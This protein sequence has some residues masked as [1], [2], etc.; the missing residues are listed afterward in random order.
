[1]SKHTHEE[2]P[3]ISQRVGSATAAGKD[4]S[5]QPFSQ[6]AA[7]RQNNEATTLRWLLWSTRLIVVIGWG[8]LVIEAMGRVLTGSV[9]VFDDNRL[10]I[11]AAI[12]L[13]STISAVLMLGSNNSNTC[14]MRADS[15]SGHRGGQRP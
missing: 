6:S 9:F 1:V 3:S 4:A 2:M 12:M 8:A 5:V 15:A 11:N 7:Q 13:L 14:S 10:A